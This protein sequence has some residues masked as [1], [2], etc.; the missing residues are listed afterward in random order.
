MRPCKGLLPSLNLI[1]NHP[2]HF[3]TFWTCCF[4]SLKCLLFSWFSQANSLPFRCQLTYCLF[5]HIPEYTMKGNSLGILYHRL[6]F[7]SFTI[8]AVCM[9]FFVHLNIT[10]KFHK[11]RKYIFYL[12]VLPLVKCLACSAH[13]L[14]FC[15]RKE[16]EEKQWA[17]KISKKILKRW[18]SWGRKHSKN[19]LEELSD[20]QCYLAISKTRFKP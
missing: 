5:K 18:Q 8:Q 3:Q 13:S 16:G 10:C 1:S 19:L 14:H 4:L 12:S 7:I 11:G 17:Q 9:Y 2:L 15:Q 6:L 20:Q